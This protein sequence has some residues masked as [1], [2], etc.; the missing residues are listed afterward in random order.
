VG[1]HSACW[2][3]SR[4]S[5]RS[6]TT[7]FRFVG[8][9]VLTLILIAIFLNTV[10]SLNQ[11]V[12]SIAHGRVIDE[13]DI[14]LSHCLYQAAI[15]GK[16]NELPSWHQANPFKVLAGKSYKPPQNYVGEVFTDSELK[17]AGWYF[18]VNSKAI[19]FWDKVRLTQR[20]QLQLIYR[21]LNQTEQFEAIT[22]KIEKLEIVVLK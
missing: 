7:A 9:I 15:D 4:I 5:F 17:Q 1:Y 3:V 2:Q 12:G 13:L 20:Y 10:K 21:D 6:S 19:Y 16:M 22:D 8:S 18:N 14:A 11:R